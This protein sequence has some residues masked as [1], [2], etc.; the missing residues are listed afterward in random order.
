MGVKVETVGRLLQKS[1]QKILAA[2]VKV[3]AMEM[4]RSS[5]ILDVFLSYC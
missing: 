1:R 4:V 5:W 3:L 2:C